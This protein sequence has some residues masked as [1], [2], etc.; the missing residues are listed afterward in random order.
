MTSSA[1]VAVASR[2]FSRNSVLRAELLARYPNTIFNDTGQI[3]EGDTLV[4][5]LRDRERA[6]IA[7]EKVDDAL[8]AQ[9]PQ[10]R[11][12]SKYGVGLDSI[13]LSALLR[14]KIRLGW[15]QGV[16][17][18]AVSELVIGFAIALLRHVRVAQAEVA[19]GIWRQTPGHQ[20]SNRVVGIVGCGHIGK[21]LITLL[22]AFGSTILA[23]DIVNFSDFYRRHNARAV[24]LEQ[25]LQE[26]E[27]VTLHVPL[28]DTTRN[29]LSADR[30]QRMRKGAYLINAARGG[31]VDEGAVKALLQAG[32]LAG[33]AFDVFGG[34][35]P[36]DLE[37]L[38][39]S[40]VI[41]TPHIGGSTVEAILAMGRAAIVGLES[42]AVPGTP[43]AARA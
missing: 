34:E 29:L 22:H 36:D 39:L 40:N 38:S 16:N 31:L 3:L 21:D 26:S 24:P 35:P 19:A 13:D 15:T 43:E 9:L 42:N 37:L 2:S 32:H 25:L 27:I 23:H 17:K 28:D 5:F 20:L 10:L 14:R 8:L 7:L 18:R 12:I 41:A 33:A 11:V 30:L 6:I 4:A 1:S